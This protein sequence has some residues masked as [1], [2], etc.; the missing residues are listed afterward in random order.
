MHLDENS[1]H[2]N[3]LLQEFY[4]Y[5]Y[6]GEALQQYFLFLIS[7]SLID[8]GVIDLVPKAQYRCTLVALYA[9]GI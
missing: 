2:W 9:N 4:I 7:F 5:I 1:L 6:E 8:I 3:S